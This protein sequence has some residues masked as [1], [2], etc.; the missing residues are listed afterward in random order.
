MDPL[1][2]AHAALSHFPIV[3]VALSFG[4]TLLGRV[5]PHT[6]DSFWFLAA[7]AGVGLL[8]VLT[9]IIVHEP[10]EHHPIYA[11]I[12][13]HEWT[14]FAGM[15][16]LLALTGGRFWLRRRG[17]DLDRTAWYP[18]VALAGIVWIVAVG[19]TGGDLVY[20]HGINVQAVNPL[21]KPPH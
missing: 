3:L 15:A 14:A 5:R 21:L 20:E 9:G 12:Q 18:V 17:S 10:Y 8:S 6:L 2:Q 7:G 16:A 4:A 11:E 19:W 1:P 13:V